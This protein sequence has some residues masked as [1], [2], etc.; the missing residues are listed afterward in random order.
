MFLHY[1]LTADLNVKFGPRY[2]GKCQNNLNQ[3]KKK[4]YNP[5][6]KQWPSTKTSTVNMT[7]C[8]SYYQK[9]YPRVSLLVKLKKE[10]KKKEEK[11]KEVF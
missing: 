5:D 9:V 8:S 2:G 4:N 11:K 10:K 7:E 1:K 3:K 6:T